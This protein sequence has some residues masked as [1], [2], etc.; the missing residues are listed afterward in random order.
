[1]SVVK[2]TVLSNKIK[3]VMAE[4]NKKYLVTW[5]AISAVEKA[6]PTPGEFAQG[7]SIEK[8]APPRQD[9]PKVYYKKLTYTQAQKRFGQLVEV[10]PTL[11]IDWQIDDLL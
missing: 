3:V 6:L 9:W 8:C 2:T 5:G 4:Y 10:L 1:M 11:T 7:H